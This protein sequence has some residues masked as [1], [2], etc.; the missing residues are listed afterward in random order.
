MGEVMRP[1]WLARWL[2]ISRS[3]LA[4]LLQGGHVGAARATTTPIRP[5]TQTAV[6]HA[7]PDSRFPIPDSR[8]TAYGVTR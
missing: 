3:R 6:S 1:V 4:P 5:P 7:P 2:V 8:L